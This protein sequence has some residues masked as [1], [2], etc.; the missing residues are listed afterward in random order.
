MKPIFAKSI[1]PVFQCVLDILEDIEGG[2]EPDPAT[3][4]ARIVRRLDAAEGRLGM[5]KD[6]ELAKYALV[7]W[8]DEVL[9]DAPWRGQEWW[10]NHCMEVDYYPERAAYSR[11]YDM[12]ADAATHSS[13][14]ALE[15]YY[16]AVILGFRG[17]YRDNPTLSPDECQFRNIPPTRGEWATRTSKSIQLGQGRPPI[18]LRPEEGY[19][20]EAL[21]GRFEL[22]GALMWFV[23][24]ATTAVILGWRLLPNGG[25]AA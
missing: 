2:D 13:K 8:I 12:A 14:D 3:N 16:L 25:S 22:L 1:D 18:D 19:G 7:A 23:I 5:T 21:R 10:A 15:V 24:L 4:K 9:I 11:F 17:I 6:W 20:G